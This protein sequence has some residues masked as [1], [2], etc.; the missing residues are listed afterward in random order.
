MKDFEA[1]V[2]AYLESQQLLGRSP[3]HLRAVGYHLRGFARWLAANRE[4]RSI[5]ELKLQ[6]LEEWVRI[7]RTRTSLRHGVL[8]PASVNKVIVVVRTFLRWVKGQGKVSTQIAGALTPMKEPRLLPQSLLSHQQA[9]TLLAKAN[10]D[11]PEGMRDR[12]MWEMLYSTGTRAAELLGLN[13]GDVDLASATAVVTGKGNKQRLVPIGVTACRYLA[14]YI[15]GIR[16]LLVADPQNSA[17]W[18][19]HDGRRVSYAALRRRLASHAS[20]LALPVAVTP[21]TFR[22]SCTTE[23]IRGGANL[24]HVK[25]LLGH[26]NLD[27]LHHYVRLTIT[28][29]KKTH[30]RCHPREREKNCA[31]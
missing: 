23:L 14:C 24:W 29:L 19:T 30:A 5:G 2:A 26:E 4:C 22:R 27:T 16:P 31:R 28:D 25:E 10:T 18:L 21:H 13:V 1:L 20:R 15:K 3:V 8:K 9:R 11:T 6:D 12:T 7:Q 17:L